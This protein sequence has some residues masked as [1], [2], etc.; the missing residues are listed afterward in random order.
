[1]IFFLLPYDNSLSQRHHCLED[2]DHISDEQDSTAC[3]QIC[4]IE[5]RH[6]ILQLKMADRGS[7]PSGITFYDS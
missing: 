7:Y 1:M 6:V 3:G 4:N 2:F 5:Q